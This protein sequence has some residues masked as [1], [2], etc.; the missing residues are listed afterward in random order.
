MGIARPLGLLLVLS[1]VSIGGACSNGDRAKFDKA[2]S[3]TVEDARQQTEELIAEKKKELKKLRKQLK[4]EAGAGSETLRT[5]IDK[6][7]KQ[8]KDLQKQLSAIGK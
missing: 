8:L 7:D 1:I 6:A 2:V 3:E 4:K 5:A